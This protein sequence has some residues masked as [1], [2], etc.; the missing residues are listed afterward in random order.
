MPR[1]GTARV[2]VLFQPR[3]V[4]VFLFAGQS[5]SRAI[6][7]NSGNV[8]V[9]LQ[10]PNPKMR[11]WNIINQRW[12]TYSAGV[13][14]DTA[15]GGVE[16]D[17]W[18]PEGEFAR[19]WCADN[20]GK[21]CHIIKM[22]INS[23]GLN[24][25]WIPSANDLFQDF[26]LEIKKALGQL[27]GRK[28]IHAICWEQG[29]TDAEDTSDA[30]AY[31][32]NLTTLI[33]A[34]RQRWGQHNSKFIFGMVRAD[35]GDFASTVQTGQQ[36]VATALASQGV[37][38]YY[39]D[40]RTLIDEAHWNAAGV[41]NCG[42]DMY[43]LFTGVYSAVPAQFGSGDWA[44]TAGDTLLTVDV[45]TLPA[46]QGSII[47][48]I[49]YQVN[50]GSWVS[51]GGIVDFNITGLT[52]GVSYNVAI[53]AK[54]RA[55]VGAASATKSGTPVGASAAV[56]VSMT[57]SS[58][59]EAPSNPKTFAAMA[60]GAADASREI[61][62]GVMTGVDVG[63]T[64]YPTVTIGGISATRIH[65]IT[66]ESSAGV[67]HALCGFYRATVPTG[68]TA[69]IVVS[70]VQ[71]YVTVFVW[72][73]MNAH[74]TLFATMGSTS[75]PTGGVAVS[76]NVNTVTDGAV[77][78]MFTSFSHGTLTHTWSGLT[79]GAEN[80]FGNFVLNSAADAEISAGET[81][82]AISCTPGAVSG[83]AANDGCAILG[84]SLQAA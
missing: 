81:P 66:S 25:R 21:V 65:E 37:G 18:G 58:I 13:N 20:P 1:L 26:E 11:I 2:P 56:D 19:R 6:G 70:G 73:V 68:T 61:I 10:T 15:G 67:V 59:D 8:P 63:N 49:E 22:G 52:N 51:S 42:Q 79:E 72:R 28:K 24:D 16:T 75:N 41:T 45:S 76:G 44:V 62:V 39:N 31:E 83:N 50:G 7:G 35:Y 43:E 23:S 64:T 48:D 69:D 40:D 46:N 54:N 55:G 78:A 29:G 12:E 14:S 84:V 77:L 36:N 32:S 80:D 5:N 9:N 82:R 27:A 4:D 34:A 60:I 38:I 71:H 57:S 30:S 53:R 47:T 33:T 74:A 3:V 17:L